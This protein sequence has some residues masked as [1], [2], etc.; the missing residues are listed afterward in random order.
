[1]FT[2]YQLLFIFVCEIMIWFHEENDQM[3]T[4]CFADLSYESLIYH[5]YNPGN[6]IVLQAL[7]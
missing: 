6:T 2:D 7:V 5:N 1:M 3:L 4:M